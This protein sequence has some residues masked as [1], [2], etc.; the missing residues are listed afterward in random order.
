MPAGFL[1]KLNIFLK[2]TKLFKNWYFYPLVY[3]KLTKKDHVI[4]ETKTGLKIKIRVNSTDLMALTHVWVI[5]EY[6]S[7]DFEI[8]DSDVVIDVGAH[9]GLFALFASQFC[10]R[11]KIFCF[12]PIKENYELLVENINSNKIK[13]IIPF[14]LA[15]SKVSGSVKIFLNDDYSGHSMFLETNDFVI[16]KSKS[17]FD[18]FSENNI[19]ECDFL[20]LDCEGAEYEIINSLTSEFLNKIKKSAIEYH[21]ADTHPELLEQLVEKLRKLSF[22]VNTRSLFSDIGFLFAIKK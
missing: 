4:F 12:E 21:L 14:N 15:V 10:K 8:N 13:N 19:Q 22:I 3:F 5:Q 1:T 7:N 17:L 2:S 18:I 11:G 16:V 9:I 6:S 20:K